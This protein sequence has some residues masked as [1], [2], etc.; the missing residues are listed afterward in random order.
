MYSCDGLNE[1]S[2]LRLV[3]LNTWSAVVELFGGVWRYDHI[4]G[5]MALGSGP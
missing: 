5:G 3:Y 4:G 1:N 2:P